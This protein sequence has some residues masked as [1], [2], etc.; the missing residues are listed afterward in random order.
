MRR[1]WL[2]WTL[3]AASCAEAPSE[4][5]DTDVVDPGPQ[6]VTQLRRLS[7]VEL[8][9]S[10][11]TLLREDST[12]VSE[13][14]PGDPR[15]P[16]DNDNA[17]QTP[18]ELVVTAA[19][20]LAAK[21]VDALV[22][23][24]GRFKRVIDCKVD[25]KGEE[26]CMRTFVTVFG[27]RALRRPLTDDEITLFTDFGLAE[28]AADGGFED[29]VAQVIR[30]LLQD[31]EF[32]FRVERG[33]VLPEEPGVIHLDGPSL[34]AR[35]SFFLLGEGPDNPLL[36]AALRGEL[37]TPEGRAVVAAE[38][39]D[40]PRA[41]ARMQRFHRQWIGWEFIPDPGE[42]PKMAHAEADALVARASFED[43]PWTD[44]FVTDDAY[45]ND[46]TAP[47]YGLPAPGTGMDF[48]WVDAA[49]TIRGGLLSSA[50][51]AFA[52]APYGD[53][54]PTKR[55]IV[56]RERLMCEE[57]DPPP[58]GVAVDTPPARSLGDCRYDRY[59]EHRSNPACSGCHQG[60]DGIGFGL[61]NLDRSG[62]WREY[63]YVIWTSEYDE[64]CP[65]EGE[66]ALPGIG[67]FSGPKEL[68]SLLVD[69]E[70]VQPCVVQHLVAYLDGT[71]PKEVDAGLVDSLTDGF[72]ASGWRM[73]QLL[74]DLVSSEHFATL[75]LEDAP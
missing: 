65:I 52:G 66:G 72:A 1:P 47:H 67:P 3:L 42:A 7:V 25:K 20:S 28:A 50:A 62:A 71:N 53:T 51:Y 39:L 13:T 30:A 58:R 33:T 8:E 12:I 41:V 73:R 46:F 11:A 38:M 36:A 44:L 9:A 37:D 34:A 10:L 14:F 35:M 40:D 54:S 29:G 48:A 24:A 26:G 61:E 31:P 75:P 55:G 4:P 69:N 21:A 64:D 32:L 56:V 17:A 60:L 2:L 19:Q 68:A 43:R 22:A 70:L 45:V 49:D 59:E 16:F 74:I 23:D 27:K 15:T 5:A 57:V 63:E 18:G 6:T